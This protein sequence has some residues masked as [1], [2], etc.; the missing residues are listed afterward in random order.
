[1]KIAKRATDKYYSLFNSMDE[2]FCIIELMYNEKGEIA[3]LV[4][5]ESNPS[6]DKHTGLG[7]VVAKTMI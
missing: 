3:D 4:F 1:M 5:R 2:G 6:F 7:L